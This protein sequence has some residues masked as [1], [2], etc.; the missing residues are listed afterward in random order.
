VG[1]RRA[2]FVASLAALAVAAPARADDAYT[3]R[4]MDG[5]VAWHNTLG[6]GLAVDPGLC[7]VAQCDTKVLHVTVPDGSFSTTPGGLTVAVHWD[8][9]QLDLGY[10]LNLYVYGPDGK[11]AAS[12]TDL[13]Y[14][15]D[16]AA[17]VQN[18]RGGDY[19]IVITP[20][21]ELGDLAYDAVAYFQPG[22]SYQ[23]KGTLAGVVSPWDDQFVVLGDIPPTP[24][25]ALLP[26][27]VPVPAHNYHLETTVAANFYTAFDRGLRHPPSCYPQE[28][29]GADADNLS[30]DTP[31]PTRCLRFDA[32]LD[33]F[34]DG[35][36]EIRAYPNNGNGTDAYQ[37][38]YNSDGTYT[39]EKA[40][41]AIFSSAHG[42]V[43]FK[44]F[45]DTGLYSLNPDGSL[46]L[47]KAMADKGRCAL[48]THNPRFGQQGDSPMRYLFPST[49]DTSDN[50]DPNDPVYPNSLFFRSGISVGWDDEYPWFIPDQYIDVTDV[51]DGNYL[52]VD[53]VNSAR[54]VRE[55]DYTDNVATACVHLEA[56]SARA[57]NAD[58]V[59]KGAAAVMAAQA[60]HRA[61]ARRHRVGARRHRRHH[62]RRH[63]TRRR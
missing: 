51:P 15:S 49:C 53:R 39:E 22:R 42:H 32:D 30:P 4:A 23:E 55:S 10:D 50:T 25:R 2:F 43:H 9:D 62:H 5:R 34:G 8:D 28:T 38:V 52:I 31:H 13:Q 29:L 12:S 1:G 3:L 7:A 27:L 26:D 24:K 17:W 46:K 54:N 44:G 35:P 61:H 36:Y 16:E 57:C 60:A 14:S 48:D 21:A 18:P 41:Q 40:G 59:P 63:H 20:S 37:V 11:L 58:E 33:N 6:T 45:D 56:S 19:K 47:V